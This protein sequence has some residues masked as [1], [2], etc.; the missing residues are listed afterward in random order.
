MVVESVELGKM[1]V[2]YSVYVVC[3]CVCFTF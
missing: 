1:N 2:M 3:V